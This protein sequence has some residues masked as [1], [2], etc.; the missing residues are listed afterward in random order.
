M[1]PND[2]VG[3]WAIDED[4]NGDFATGYPIARGLILTVAHLFP[5]DE[6]ALSKVEVVFLH[7]DKE[8]LEATLLWSGFWRTDGVDTL[9]AA[10]I[11]CDFPREVQ[12]R[13]VLKREPLSPGLVEWRSKGY[14][15]IKRGAHGDPEAPLDFH[16]KFQVPSDD[17]PLIPLQVDGAS[18]ERL[19]EED[20]KGA[21]GAPVFVGAHLVAV[22]V[23]GEQFP[24]DK[25]VELNAVPVWRFAQRPDFIEHFGGISVEEFEAKESR[26]SKGV[27]RRI[28]RALRKI[29]NPDVAEDLAE[30]FDLELETEGCPLKDSPNAI[31]VIAEKLLDDPTLVKEICELRREYRRKQEEDETQLAEIEDELLPLRYSADQRREF[32]DALRERNAILIE[33]AVYSLAGAETWMSAVDRRKTDF[34]VTDPV[35]DDRE[36]AGADSFDVWHWRGEAGMFLSTKNL[37]PGEMSAQAIAASILHELAELR[38]SPNQLPTAVEAWESLRAGDMTLESNPDAQAE[39]SELA[40]VL[41]ETLKARRGS[42]YCV[43]RVNDDAVP[44]STLIDALGLINEHVPQLDF[45]EI[46]RRSPNAPHEAPVLELLRNRVERQS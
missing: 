28:Q 16:G 39:F 14:A 21:S 2:L 36:G 34:S 41:N 30:A 33:D 3:I 5:S 7:R 24:A 44:R 20:W 38:L 19:N 31:D 45:L 4:G 17:Q 12:P 23:G 8:P 43:I 42:Q 10:L 35:D 46:S 37:G 18:R 1:N 26:W 40:R 11:T 27:K 15:R 32:W 22:F 13:T 9:D 29:V 25:L 6:N